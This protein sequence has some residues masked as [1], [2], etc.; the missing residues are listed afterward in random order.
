MI[1]CTITIVH[2]NQITIYTE[3]IHFSLMF[4]IGA[5]VWWRLGM[6]ERVAAGGRYNDKKFD[7]IKNSIANIKSSVK[8]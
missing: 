1:L 6:H 5:V 7:K 2:Y 3:K 8:Q 4:S